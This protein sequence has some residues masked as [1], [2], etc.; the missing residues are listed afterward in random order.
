MS[1]LWYILWKSKKEIWLSKDK[2]T[3]VDKHI[4]MDES[5][6]YISEY[7]ALSGKSRFNKEVNQAHKSRIIKGKNSFLPPE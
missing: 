1:V 6:Q 5:I 7:Y 3:R 2:S 4:A